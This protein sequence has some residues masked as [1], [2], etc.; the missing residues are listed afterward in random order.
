M[1][2][3]LGVLLIPYSYNVLI[4]LLGFKS[5]TN[6]AFFPTLSVKHLN[7]FWKLRSVD[8]I[9]SSKTT[10]STHGNVTPVVSILFAK[11]I[12]PFPST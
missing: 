3:V 12:N 10:I 2:P 9:S 11:M 6:P 4:I 7:I 5:T 8:F 1:S